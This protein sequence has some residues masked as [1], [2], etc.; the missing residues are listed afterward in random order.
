MAINEQLLKDASEFLRVSREELIKKYEEAG[1]NYSGFVKWTY[2]SEKEW[3]NRNIN[4]TD[5]NDVAKFYQETWNYIPELVEAWT[6]DKY[7][8]L[9]K[10]IEII[11]E[12]KHKKVVDY[13][14]GI[15]EASVLQAKNRL[16]ATAVD[17]PGNTFNF[18]KWR[19]K[20]H[21]LNIKTIDII[22]SGFPLKV[23]YDVITCFEVIQHVLDPKALIEHF[24]EHLNKGGLFIMTARFKG[25]YALALKENEKYH[26]KFKEVVESKGFKQEQKIHMWGPQ[27]ENGKYLEVYKKQNNSALI[28]KI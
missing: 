27:D 22:P 28:R 21:G 25:N 15:G 3:L 20:K 8:L 23:K 24:Y 14:A 12:N 16:D 5:E 2:V 18:A 10:T 9:Q 17:L 4:Q 13:G 6:P 11:I 7:R 19:F 1:K 26:N